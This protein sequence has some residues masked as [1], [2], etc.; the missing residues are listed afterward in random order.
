MQQSQHIT[1]ATFP[2]SLK[3]VYTN[4]CAEPPRLHVFDAHM[5]DGQ[6]ALRLYTDPE[7]FI[8]QWVEEQLKLQKEAKKARK[9]RRAKMKGAKDGAAA[10]DPAA[11]MKKKPAKLERVRYDPVTGEKI[12]ARMQA[13]AQP[14]GQQ[15]PAQP[16]VVV[17]VQAVAVPVDDEVVISAPRAHVPVLSRSSN[18]SVSSQHEGTI[19]F[20]ALDAS[21]SDS[22]SAPPTA[23]DERHHSTSS[24]HQSGTV[25]PTPADDDDDESPPPDPASSAPGVPPPAV[26]TGGGAAVPTSAPPSKPSHKTDD[27]AAKKAKEGKAKKDSSSSS[28]G[29]KDKK[30]SKKDKTPRGDAHS[31]PHSAPPPVPHSAPPPLQHSA[32]KPTAAV[33]IAAPIAPPPP[34]M[35]SSGGPISAP[36]PPMPGRKLGAP[37]A[38]SRGG[39][40]EQ[41]S[42]GTALKKVEP[43][44]RAAA[45][46]DG[47]SALLGAIQ[48]GV[49]L[50][51][52]STRKLADK[53][54]DNKDGAISVADILARRIAFVGNDKD[55]DSDSDGWDDGEWD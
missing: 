22:G 48:S 19:D 13:A 18:P 43:N 47:R 36:P 26:P 49:S 11:K 37:A 3:A 29:K 8:D 5:P 28:S 55:E 16:Q 27:K 38:G 41:I 23:R 10:A 52:A 12:T 33:P 4:E 42:A 32:P 7:F 9:E 35:P 20:S 31:V 51:A 30:S 39:L 54:A 53:K 46:A 21:E 1:S 17:A 6:K 45:P 44:E 24:A 34:P 50:K 25:T 40:L 14:A 15:R 2:A